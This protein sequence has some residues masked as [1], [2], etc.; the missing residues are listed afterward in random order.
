[1]RLNRDSS[2]RVFWIVVSSCTSPHMHT[3]TQK[4]RNTHTHL[5]NQLKMKG[6]IQFCGLPTTLF[7]FNKHCQHRLENINPHKEPLHV[8]RALLCW[9]CDNCLL[10]EWW[11]NLLGMETMPPRRHPVQRKTRL[12]WPETAPRDRPGATVNPEKK[13]NHR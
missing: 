2:Q 10:G 3:Q 12:I 4:Y 13:T 5:T 1:M 7:T 11:V 8:E 9:V 6:Y